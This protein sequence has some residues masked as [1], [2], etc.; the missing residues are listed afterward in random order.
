MWGLIGGLALILSSGA[1][2]AAEMGHQLDL[3]NTYRGWIALGLF[4]LAYLLVIFE[5]NLHLRKSKPVMVA[6]GVIWILVA[7]AY[8]YAYAYASACL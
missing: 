3:T 1:V 4:I 2:N 6:A 8:A 7:V 5:E